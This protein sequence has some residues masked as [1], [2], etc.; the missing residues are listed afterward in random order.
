M[1]R[2]TYVSTNSTTPSMQDPNCIKDNRVSKLLLSIDELAEVGGI[3]PPTPTL[4][5]CALPTELD[6]PD[7]QSNIL[8][9]QAWQFA[10]TVQH[11]YVKKSYVITT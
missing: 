3:E 7:L 8:A 5:C 11:S 10:F 6:L 1:F 4:M 2:N 9:E